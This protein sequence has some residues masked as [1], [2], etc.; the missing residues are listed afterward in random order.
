MAGKITYYAMVGPEHPADQ[1]LGLLR[2]LL[3]DDGPEDEGLRDDLSWRKTTLIVE[4]DN[5]SLDDELVEV[6][7]EQAGRIVE[8]FRAKRASEP[9]S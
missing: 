9:G 7:H 8:Y 2:R 6:T 4:H 3:H 1:P 5:G